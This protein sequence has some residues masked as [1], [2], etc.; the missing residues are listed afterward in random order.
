MIKSGPI[1]VQVM[2]ATWLRAKSQWPITSV[3]L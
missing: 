3:E 1:R 2:V